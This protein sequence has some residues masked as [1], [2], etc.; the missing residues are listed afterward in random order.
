MIVQ[1]KVS[2]DR[3]NDFLHEVHNLTLMT[4][5]FGPQTLHLDRAPR[6][7]RPGPGGAHRRFKHIDKPLTYRHPQRIFHL[8]LRAHENSHSWP[9][10]EKV[11]LVGRG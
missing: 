4:Y 7:L 1:A 9:L 6:C 10:P 5:F 3:I 11:P 8:V 2:L